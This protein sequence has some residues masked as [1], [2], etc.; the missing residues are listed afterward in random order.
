[1]S[2]IQ[3]KTPFISWYQTD[4]SV[5]IYILLNNVTNPII[6]IDQKHL[7]FSGYSNNN[8]YQISFELFDSIVIDNNASSYKIKDNQCEFFLT[9]TNES[10]KWLRLPNDKT[11]YKN[12]IK[13]NWDYYIDSDDD[14]DNNHANSDNI[15]MDSMGMNDMNG[16][17]IE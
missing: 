12:N 8:L 1:M 17:D 9:K 15:G 16:M 7:S 4:N 10:E 5:I 14:N 11:L 3:S 6:N 2:T 13:Y